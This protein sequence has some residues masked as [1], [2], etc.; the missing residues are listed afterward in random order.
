VTGGAGRRHRRRLGRVLVVVAAVLVVGAAAAAATGFGLPKPETSGQAHSA[1]PPATGQVTRQ[2]L[3]DIQ[4]EN[5]EL[6]YGSATTVTG[7]A[8]GTVTALPAPGSTLTRGQALYHL[9]N[10]PVVML[11]GSLPAYRELSPGTKG[12]DVKQFEQ[13]LYEMGYR[14][15]TV[16]DSYSATTVAAVKKWQG[17]L[18]LPK[19]GTVELGRVV[20]AAGPVR[21]DS[22]KAA[23]GD[24]VQ[25]GLALLTYT[26]TSRVVT[27]E[28][29]VSDQRLAVKA[30]GVTVTLPAGKSVPG[31]I[32]KTATVIQPAEGQS[33]AATKIEVTVTVED[34][35][36]LA[37]LDQATVDVGFTASTR[38]DVL[39]VPVAA[40]L[41]LAEGGYGV[42][43]VTGTAT[44]I[45]AV[46]TGLFA[47]GRVEISGDGLTEGMTVGMPS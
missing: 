29:K 19:T 27:V 1:L 23:V 11:Y 10:A 15:F 41:A 40:L 32:T 36:A 45:V 6:G 18:G 39:T 47:G 46:H 37:G 22:Q 16:D 30:A 42:Q 25:P 44:R 12:A 31:K 34:E 26:G 9:D 8:G 13:N 2:T 4:K 17:D 5:G 33:P 43:V 21:V 7:R 28:L 35:T 14:G 24:A 20:Y 3:V 38:A